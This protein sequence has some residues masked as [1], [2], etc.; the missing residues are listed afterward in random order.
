MLEVPLDRSLRAM[1]LGN[2]H[3]SCQALVPTS[4]DASEIQSVEARSRGRFLSHNYL[5]F[6]HLLLSFPL[7]T[8]REACRS[9]A[10]SLRH[11][12]NV[13]R[14]VASTRSLP[15][16]HDSRMRMFLLQQRVHAPAEHV[17]QLPLDLLMR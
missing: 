9:P 15:H 17:A 12:R 14:V 11:G 13:L 4:L 7:H 10:L 2:R 16:V 5:T 6:L 1:E 3:S 8:C